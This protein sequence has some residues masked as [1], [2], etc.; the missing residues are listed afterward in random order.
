MNVSG[1]SYR[2]CGKFPDAATELAG[3]DGLGSEDSILEQ[4]KTVFEGN[5]NCTKTPGEGQC[6]GW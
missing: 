6:D 1:N 4:L 3:Y 2:K 5:V